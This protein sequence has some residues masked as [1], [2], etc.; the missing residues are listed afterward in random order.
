VRNPLAQAY[1]YG[2][3]LGPIA[4]PCAGPFLVALLAISVGLADTLAQVGSFA[5]YGL[6]FGL[7]LVVLGALGAA[8]GQAVSRLVARH[9]GLVLRG[10]GLLVIVTALYELTS[11]GVPV[12]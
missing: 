11:S 1:L 9:H 6:G 10:A 7:P 4:L 2:V 12:V 8:R 5:V 3:L